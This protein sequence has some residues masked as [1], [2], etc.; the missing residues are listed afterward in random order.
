VLF[1]RQVAGDDAIR[2]LDREALLV[3]ATDEAGGVWSRVIRPD[4]KGSWQRIPGPATTG[5]KYELWQSY[6][7]LDEIDWR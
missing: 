2:L 6:G 1:D 3:V 5:G 7:L 4:D